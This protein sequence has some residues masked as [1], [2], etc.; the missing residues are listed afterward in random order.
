MDQ[1]ISF[2]VAGTALLLAFLIFANINQSNCRAN[3][4]FGLFI[5]CIFIIQFNDLL[6]KTQF[7]KTRML[8][9]DF[10]GITDFQRKLLA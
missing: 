8:I 4:W 10:L 3:R 7:L 9:N 5:F 2:F 6:E 1:L